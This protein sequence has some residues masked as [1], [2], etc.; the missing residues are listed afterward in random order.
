MS[1][2]PHPGAHSRDREEPFRSYS[3]ES[4]LS[5]RVP[6]DVGR[7][8]LYERSLLTALGYHNDLPRVAAMIDSGLLDPASLITRRA[9]LADAP[10]EIERLATDPGDDV[11]VLIDVAS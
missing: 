8:L 9:P 5:I 10:A 7:L 6:V 11:K 3:R 2:W 1:A 4:L